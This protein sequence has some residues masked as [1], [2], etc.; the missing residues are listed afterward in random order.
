M[1]EDKMPFTAHLEELRRRIVYCAIAVGIGFVACYFF[2]ER[3]FEV[4][5]QPLLNVLQGD[6][7]ADAPAVAEGAEGTK[8]GDRPLIYTA[9]HELFIV[10]LKVSFLGGVALAMPVIMFQVWRFIAPGLYANERRYLY[11]VAFFSAFFFVG[12]A[13]FGY[14]VVFPF[15]FRFFVSFA[16]ETIVPMISTKEYFSF[17][18]RLLIAFGVIFELP[19]FAFIL[20]KIGLINS[21]FLRRQRKYAILLVFCTAAFL[22]PPDVFTQLL[23]AGPLIILFELS[24]IIVRIF[25]KKPK[26]ELAGDESAAGASSDS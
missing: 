18:T 25:E 19:V 7:P 22:T 17:A 3:M 24:V 2:K 16:N 1:S 4:L 21:R 20:A 26:D 9:P 13:L 15:G 6:M 23:M 12:G 11:P 14:M 10:Y 8:G 5:M